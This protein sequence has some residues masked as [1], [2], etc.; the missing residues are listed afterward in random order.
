MLYISTQN[1]S[2]TFTNWLQLLLIH[3]IKINRFIAGS[4][5]R[6]FVMGKLL[7]VCI[8]LHD[9]MVQRDIRYCSMHSFQV[10]I[11]HIATVQAAVC[12]FTH[13]YCAY[14]SMSLYTLPLC[15]LHCLFT[16]CYCACCSM[17]LYT[18]L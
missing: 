10:L 4:H 5:R 14:C 6:S 11:L 13:C 18:L 2:A 16:R 17:S 9:K 8:T 1:V 3:I 15:M 7:V 12:L